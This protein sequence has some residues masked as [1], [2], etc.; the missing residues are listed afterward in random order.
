MADWLL[1][2]LD[3]IYSEAMTQG[4]SSE[5]EDYSYNLG[6]MVSLEEDEF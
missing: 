5:L 1:A 4:I 6:A 2:E 3:R